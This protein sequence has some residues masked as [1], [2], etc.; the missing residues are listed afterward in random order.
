[1]L[2]EIDMVEL[3]RTRF[4]QWLLNAEQAKFSPVASA[5]GETMRLETEIRQYFE[6]L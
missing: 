3:D 1:M 4:S 2:Y 6:T 5:P